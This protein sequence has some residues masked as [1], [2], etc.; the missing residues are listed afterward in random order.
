VLYR[1]KY[2]ASC[3]GFENTACVL[4]NFF[5]SRYTYMLYAIYPICI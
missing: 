2:V 4:F 1:I 5:W 3:G